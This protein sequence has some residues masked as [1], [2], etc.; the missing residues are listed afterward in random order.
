VEGDSSD[1]EG[2]SFL[3]D[4]TVTDSQ[5]VEE[6]AWVPLVGMVPEWCR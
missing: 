4:D 1:D 5:G 3:P 2:D 6:M